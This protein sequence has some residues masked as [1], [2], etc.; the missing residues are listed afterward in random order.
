[1]ASAVTVNSGA[2][3]AGNGSSGNLINNGT[4]SPGN[5]IGTIIVNGN[6]TQ[7][8]GGALNIEI[9][10]AGLTDLLQITGTAALD[11]TLNILPLGSI[12][13][14]AKNTY[15]FLTAAGGVSGQFATVTPVAGLQFT[16]S[17]LPNAVQLII[18]GSNFSS[19]VSSGNAGIIASYLDQIVANGTASADLNTVLN[20]LSDAAA[21]GTATLTAALNQISPDP[22]REM[23]FLSFE[24]TN[25]LRQSISNQQQRIIDTYVLK[26]LDVD[27]I[28]SESLASFQKHLQGRNLRGGFQPMN[29]NAK[30]SRRSNTA[31]D[32][33]AALSFNESSAPVRKMVQ[34]GKSNVWIE[35]AGQYQRK[36]NSSPLVGTKDHTY[37]TTVG[38]DTLVAPNTYVGILASIMNTHF[39]W[40]QHRGKGS[41]NGYF[42]GIYALWLSDTGF[43]LD[44][45]ATIGGE[46]YKARRN[47]NFQTINR[48]ARSKHNGVT[49]ATDLEAG[50]LWT[51][52][53][54]LIQPFFNFAY[55]AAHEGSFNEKG[56]NSLNAHLN[57]KTSQFS[58]TEL[59]P[60]LSYFFTT[61]DETIIYPSAKL[62]WVQKRPW[63]NKGKRDKF[64]FRDQNFKTTVY[65]DNRVRNML[66]PGLALTAQFKNGLYVTG[67]V[68]AEAGSG[69][70]LGQVMLNLG[71]NF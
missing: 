66:S 43:Y 36:K 50:Y 21:Q 23:G 67:D 56:A 16:I 10:P 3:Y 33:L 47:I 28:A 53:K 11:G 57:S 44:G 51:L 35:P 12:A 71:Y 58:R 25:L 26:T 19:L 38:A 69:E 41:V 40:T 59:G 4:V 39:D 60:I 29:F 24:Q 5:S 15:T 9:T 65:G 6:Y 52:G 2:S 45:Q 68:N 54:T 30:A 32:R 20:A 13:S 7:G 31:K 37:G 46:R 64:N 63:G 61:C 17:Y 22:Y 42:G 62:S 48:T 55:V 14:F 8:S 34:I 18:Q 1:L 70:R 27:E 49:V